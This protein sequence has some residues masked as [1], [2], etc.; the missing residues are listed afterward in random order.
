[1][2]TWDDKHMY[3]W[4]GWMRSLINVRERINDWTLSPEADSIN[5]YKFPIF[6][7]NNF[8]LSPVL[9][10]IVGLMAIPQTFEWIMANIIEGTDY[11]IVANPGHEGVRQL[12]VLLGLVIAFA[13]VLPYVMTWGLPNLKSVSIK[14]HEEKRWNRRRAV[15]ENIRESVNEDLSRWQQQDTIN[16]LLRN[17]REQRRTYKDFTPKKDI[18]AHKFNTERKSIYISPGVYT[19][20]EFRMAHVRTYVTDREDYIN[21]TQ[22]EVE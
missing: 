7:A 1:M 3:N 13:L 11:L 4:I 12:R 2:A 21:R 19:R 22:E 5:V 8:I 18:K 16:E 14:K 6:I 9:F 10:F 20:D 17:V 15:I